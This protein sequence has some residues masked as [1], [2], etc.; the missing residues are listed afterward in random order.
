MEEKKGLISRL[1]GTKKSS[2]CCSVRIEEIAEESETNPAE[3]KTE[4][5]GQISEKQKEE[6][7]AEN[8][9]TR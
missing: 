4:C 2:G 8:N 9:K 7:Q 5:C 6:R 1:F 3:R